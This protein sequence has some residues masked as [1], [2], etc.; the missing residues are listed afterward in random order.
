MIKCVEMIR[1]DIFGKKM[2]SIGYIG[3]DD[4]TYEVFTN[5]SEGNEEELQELVKPIKERTS[6]K[7]K[8]NIIEEEVTIQTNQK[9][10]IISLCFAYRD[11]TYGKR[12]TVDNVEKFDKLSVD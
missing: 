3:Q 5:P 2:Y 8:G 6:R 12:F 4:K 11:Y 7:V 10:W 1:L 9:E